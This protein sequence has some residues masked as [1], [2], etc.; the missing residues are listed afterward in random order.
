MKNEQ[1]LN[2]LLSEIPKGSVVLSSW[3]VKNGYS[4]ALQQRYKKSGWFASIGNGAMVRVREEPELYGA[5]YALQYQA[6]Y[7]I[8]LGAGSALAMLGKSHYLPLGE[9]VTDLFLSGERKMPGWF[10]NYAWKQP[11]AIHATHF[12]P[13][14]IGLLEKEAGAY[15]IIISKAER[16]ILECLYLC[17][18]E[19]DIIGCYQLMEGLNTL[20]P[21][22]LQTLLEQCKSVK[23]NRLFLFLA[24]KIHHAW[25]DGLDLKRINLGSG[26]RS[27]IKSGVFIPKYD[28]TVPKELTLNEIPGL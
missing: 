11:F 13:D 2:R 18:D 8:H 12:I 27:I 16:A 17:N 28:I 24:E 14:A 9:P 7:E 5:I 26:K 15:N 3:L 4:Y 10:V 21:N 1:K 25:F 6:G 19:S 20:Y 22:L 23:V